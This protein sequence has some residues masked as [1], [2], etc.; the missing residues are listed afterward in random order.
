[1]D[2]G[3]MQR[4]LSVRAT[5]N[6]NHKF[7][8]LFNLINR[9]DWLLLAHDHVAN[10]AGSKTAGCDGITMRVFDENLE[11]NLTAIRTDLKR[12]KFQPAPVRRV[13]IPKANGKMRK[14]G[15][16]AIRDRIVQEALRMAL[17]PIYEADFC[18]DSYGF[19]PGRRTMDAIVHL[20][21]YMMESMKYFWVIE[22]DISAYFDTI[23]HRKLM[24]LLGRRIEDGKILDLIWSFLR[25]GVMERRL[26]QDTNTGT[27]QGG[28]ISP[29]LANI[30]L[31]ELDTYMLRYIRLPRNERDKR[32]RD[33]LGN[34]AYARYAD[35][36]V[37]LCNGSKTDA[38]AMRDELQTFLTTKLRLKLSMEKTKVTHL[39]EGFTFLGFGLKR[40]RSKTDGKTTRILIPAEKAK[41][42]LN[43]LKAIFSPSTMET[44]LSTKLA[45]AN[46]V[47]K[48]W[49]QYY[50]HTSCPSKTFGT[51]DRHTF[52]LVMHWISRKHRSSIKKTHRVYYRD[53]TIR[54]ET[55]YL[56]EHSE[57]KQRNVNGGGKVQRGAGE[58][59]NT[60]YPAYLPGDLLSMDC[61]F[62]SSGLAGSPAGER[63]RRLA[64]LRR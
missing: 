26:F 55:A 31:H 62:T 20:R 29:L 42:H 56:A 1:M 34:F 35:D 21:A 19:R 44:S 12:G 50:Q 14:L 46:R 40:G 57:T 45:A 4:R 17:E 43:V 61:G 48:G 8:D 18:Q 53:G 11:D 32:R 10:N 25:S 2:I 30:Y 27:P 60:R 22:G 24:K 64:S 16:P 38:L 37:V 33:K 63:R 7:G 52:W 39:N 58:M 15:I 13:L 41:G 23:N 3:E 5:E 6:P 54:T 59:G 28:I 36:F 51:L 47:I 9:M 49:C